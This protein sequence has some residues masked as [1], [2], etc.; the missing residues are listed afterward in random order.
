MDGIQR[1]EEFASKSYRQLQTEKWRMLM[2]KEAS[3]AYWE[4]YDNVK[5]V[6]CQSSASLQRL[7]RSC[8]RR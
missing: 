4:G 3:L 2:S 8:V 1:K 7:S 5:D 6:V